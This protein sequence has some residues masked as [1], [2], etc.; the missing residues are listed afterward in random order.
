M[1]TGDRVGS[2]W[3]R[4]SRDRLKNTQ[5]LGHIPGLHIWSIVNFNFQVLGINWRLNFVTDFKYVYTSTKPWH[6]TLELVNSILHP[7]II[8]PWSLFSYIHLCLFFEYFWSILYLEMA[9]FFQFLN[10]STYIWFDEIISLNL[11][12]K[13]G[14]EMYQEGLPDR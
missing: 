9:F 1:E 6:P 12:V 11:R 2:S 3:I 10:P 5:S 7:F 13:K 14:H 8:N 4:I